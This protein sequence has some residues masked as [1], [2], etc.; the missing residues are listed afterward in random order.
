[1]ALP[2]TLPSKRAVQG[3]TDLPQLP[4]RRQFWGVLHSQCT[5]GHEADMSSV[6][7]CSDLLALCDYVLP[8]SQALGRA[9]LPCP[10]Q[11]GSHGAPQ[12]VPAVML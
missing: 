1:M 5:C 11:P 2:I 9:G 4:A 3:L 12:R 7:F 6:V 10:A 8:T